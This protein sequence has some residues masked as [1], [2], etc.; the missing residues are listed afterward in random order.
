MTSKEAVKELG[1]NWE[2]I[3]CTEQEVVDQFELPRVFFLDISDDVVIERLSLCM[4][5]PVSGERYHNIY[6]PAPRP[7]VYSRLQQ[8]P[9][10]SEEKIQARLDMYHANVEELEE[11]YQ[12]IIHINADQDPYTV[13]EIIESHIVK[14]LSK[15]LPEEP[16]LP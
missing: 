15:S 7:E 16:T 3:Q 1:R 12:D 6:N 5:D 9:E 2:P 10:L 13:F 4:T 8:N 14:P 11:F